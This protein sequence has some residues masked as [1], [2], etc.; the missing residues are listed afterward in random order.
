MRAG[1]F[2]NA[3][4]GLAFLFLKIDQVLVQNAKDPVQ[5]AED[6][7]DLIG[8]PARLLNDPGHARVNHRRRS[9]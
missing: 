2:Y 6:F 8:M 3:F 7:L 1:Q 5:A 9:A 4:D